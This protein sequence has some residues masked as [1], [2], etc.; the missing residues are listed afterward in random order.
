VSA[1]AAIRSRQGGEAVPTA[2]LLLARERVI[3]ATAG[4][5]GLFP[6]GGPQRGTTIVV[7]PGAVSL[8]GERRV[9]PGRISVTPGAVSATPGATTLALEILA[10]VSA[11]GHFCAAVGM[12]NLGIAAAAE[13][14]V[15]LDRLLLVP[16]PGPAG[17]WQ[18]VI[19]SLLDAVAAVLLAPSAPVRP[20]DQRK[21]SGRAKD[22]GAIL[23]VLDRWG[24]WSEPG[25][26]RCSATASSWSGLGNG[27]GLLR[28][29]SI[30][31][32]MRGRGAAV[33]PLRSALALSA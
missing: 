8:G 11:A 31:V 23:I 28:S 26:L 21:L 18:Q 5:A 2:S 20:V 15:A 25:D 1:A 9:A 30:D 19:A 4:L 17:R 29:R 10:G 33:R 24:R 7:T 12:A 14:K 3:P 6:G 27:H 22:R 16:S 32:E 13:R